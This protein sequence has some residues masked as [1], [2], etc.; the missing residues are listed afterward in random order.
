MGA[1]A[2]TMQSTA[3]AASSA[4]SA[5]L[6]EL[7]AIRQSIFNRTKDITIEE[8]HKLG[9]RAESVYDLESFD[10][11]T[12]RIELNTEWQGVIEK[13]KQVFESL[14]KEFGSSRKLIKENN[15]LEKGI[16]R[17]F[18][19]FEDGSSIQIRFLGKSG[20]PKI[21]IIDTLKNIKEKITFK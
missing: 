11:T 18:Y 5:A 16:Q 15:V 17:I 20:Q 21:D 14:K 10:K 1:Y 13:A 3:N 9:F 12:G 8:A 6:A 4:V 19:A 2:Q 7:E